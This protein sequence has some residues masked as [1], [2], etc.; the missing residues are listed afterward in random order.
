MR[1][2][3]VVLCLWCGAARALEVSATD[4]V[5]SATG[6]APVLEAGLGT[7][8][9]GTVATGRRLAGDGAG[10]D[11]SGGGKYAHF[12]GML[13]CFGFAIAVWTSGKV[14]A[15]AGAPALVG[16][17]VCGIVLG[18]HVAEF[19]S[20]KHDP[21]ATVIALVGE[22]CDFSNLLNAFLFS[23][24]SASASTRSRQG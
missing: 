6:A 7:G 9:D 10:S 16:Q 19:I 4:K 23:R 14:S 15:Y 2:A 24:R 1:L 13:R 5:A 22:V 3:V 17:I 20:N 18:P 8:A 12:Y 21:T 11:H